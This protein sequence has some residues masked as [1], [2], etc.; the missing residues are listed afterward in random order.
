MNADKGYRIFLASGET[1]DVSATSLR[2][3]LRQ[4]GKQVPETSIVAAIER[5][6]LPIPE[7]D[8]RPFL[9]VLLKNP[10]Y[11]LPIDE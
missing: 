9:A 11:P 7:D 8:A 6:C 10:N 5:A 2:T 4:L 1:R 3:A